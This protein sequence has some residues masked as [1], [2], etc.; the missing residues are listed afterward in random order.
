MGT[1]EYLQDT[2]NEWLRHA[3]AK[4]GVLVG[5]VVGGIAAASG[6]IQGAF[7]VCVVL[8]VWVAFAVSCLA[9]ALVISLS[10][11]I[12]MLDAPDGRRWLRHL[13]SP[14]PLFFGHAAHLTPDKL[15]DMLAPQ[16]AGN[17]VDLWRAEQI[18]TNSRIAV[19]KFNRFTTATWTVFIGIAPLLSIP[20][21]V[22]RSR[23]VRRK[24]HDS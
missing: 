24:A 19:T 6:V 10:S 9:I 15:V 20:L 1:M 5:V 12:P 16:S 23:A 13:E 11:F 21:L 8:G 17:Q 18:I 14:N 4:N 7:S 3:E 22:Y 2:V